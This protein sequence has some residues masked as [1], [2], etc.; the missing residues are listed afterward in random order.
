MYLNTLT[1]QDF[2]CYAYDILLKS[3]SALN[4]EHTPTPVF[5][6]S[7]FNFV[8]FSIIVHGNDNSY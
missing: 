3:C 6:L 8:Y 1:K 2:C 5:S 7:T 4:K